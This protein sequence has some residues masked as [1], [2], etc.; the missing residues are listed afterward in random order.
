MFSHWAVGAFQW[1]LEQKW[2]E[3]PPLYSNHALQQLLWYHDLATQLAVHLHKQE[4]TRQQR[5][6]QPDSDD[7]C[8]IKRHIK[9]E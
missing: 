5:G 7:M 8:H 4:P 2:L 6:T 3:Q 9:K 1:E